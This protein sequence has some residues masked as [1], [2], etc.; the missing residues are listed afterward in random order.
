MFIVIEGLDGAGK[1]TQVAMIREEFAARGIETEY[2]H[3][4]RFDASAYGETIARFLRG[5]FGDADTVDP[6]LAALLYAGDRRCAAPVIEGW[7]AEGKAVVVDRYVASNIAYQCA[8]VTDRDDK[9]RMRQWILQREYGDYAIPRPDITLFL[10]V[11]FGFTVSRL[12]GER[13]G[14][15]RD[16]LDGKKDI[17]EASLPLQER[18]RLEYL[19]LAAT[20][21]STA[22]I[23]C[24]SEEG[25]MLPPREIFG[26]IAEVIFGNRKAR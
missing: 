19:D 14:D 17:H 26:K 20:D 9:R 15:D 23:D 24:A 13:S 3:F 18:V 4:P 5:D 21:R 6:Q 12:T 1:S 8:K 25:E 7:L 10:D 2:L 11:P 16:Y 22:V